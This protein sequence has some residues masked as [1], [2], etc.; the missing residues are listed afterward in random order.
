MMK[1]TMI[2]TV[3][4]TIKKQALFKNTIAT[5]AIGSKLTVA[6]LLF[7]SSFSHAFEDETKIDPKLTEEWKTVTKVDTSKNI[8]SDAV[9]LFD[10]SS[11]E[12]WQDGE[13]KPVTWTL[14]D[15]IMTVVPGA[16][17]IKTKESFCDMQLH[18]EWRSPEQVKG[19][20]GQHDGNSGVFI[21]GRYEIQVLNSYNNDTYAN[22][23]AG[24]IYKQYA[25]LVNATKPVMEWQSYDIIFTAPRFD[26]TGKLIS[27]ARFTALHN[28]VLIQNNV[29]IE[30]STTYKGQ[31]KYQAHGCAP[32]NLQDHGSL[33]SYRNIWAR[34]L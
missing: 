2:T 16:K 19:K 23:Q 21:Q 10:G 18:L 5:K 13:G 11:L 22:G 3:I 7:V 4:N 34:K 17:G 25:P 8:P 33:V 6:S 30:G 24:A 9:I 26:A 14:A 1:N 31:P 12:Q 28:G 27:K 15:Q 29:E 32:I 20:T